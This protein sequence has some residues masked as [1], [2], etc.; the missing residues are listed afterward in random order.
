MLKSVSGKFFAFSQVNDVK[1]V[2]TWD[3]LSTGMEDKE[4]ERNI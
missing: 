1:T 4:G 3:S 2:D